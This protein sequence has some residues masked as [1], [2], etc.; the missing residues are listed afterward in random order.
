MAPGDASCKSET[1]QKHTLK[2]LNITK[3]QSTLL[4]VRGTTPNTN[5]TKT[6]KLNNIERN[7]LVD[8]VARG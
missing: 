7:K 6:Q 5:K 3:M 1:C 8:Y 4:E 2:K